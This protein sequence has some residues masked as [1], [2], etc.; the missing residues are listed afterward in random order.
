MLQI[1]IPKLPMRN[2]ALTI[3][4]YVD[5]LGFSLINDYGDYLLLEKDQIELH[6]FAHPE[7]IPEENDGQVYCRV[8]DINAWYQEL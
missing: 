3:S 5:Q 7:I 8:S 2:K 4:Y 6:F 1:A